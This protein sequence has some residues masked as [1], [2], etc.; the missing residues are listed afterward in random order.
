[1]LCGRLPVG[2]V[3]TS[4]HLC[5][6]DTAVVQ[7]Y[8]LPWVCYHDGMST[9]LLVRDL[10]CAVDVWYYSTMCWST[11]CRLIVRVLVKGSNGRGQ[12]QEISNLGLPIVQHVD[13]IGARYFPAHG[14]GFAPFTVSWPAVET[15]R[16]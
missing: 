5:Y 11:M 16:G 12:Q 9:S 6:F 1:M 15:I 8:T 10:R 7:W 4:A 13:E 14:T 2:D 3:S